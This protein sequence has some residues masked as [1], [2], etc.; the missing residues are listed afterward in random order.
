MMADAGVTA[1]VTPEDEAGMGHG[2]PPI[3]QLIAAGIRPNL[4]I[5]TCMAA[6]SDQFTAM[7]FALS[8]ARA[9]TNDVQI[10]QDGNPWDLRLSARDVLELAT[11]AGARALGMED[12]IGSLTAGKQADIITIRTDDISMIPAID[13]VAAVVHHASRR[14]IDNVFIAGRRLKANGVVGGADIAALAAEASR[15]SAELME[16]AGISVGWVPSA[17]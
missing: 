3:G 14:A 2:W 15:R 17:G 13:P 9:S 12:K 8:L 11:I 1:C 10:Q 7:R 16:R 4:G 6:G 5:D